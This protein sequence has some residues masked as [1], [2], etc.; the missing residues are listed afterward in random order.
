MIVLAL[1]NLAFT[2]ELADQVTWSDQVLELAV[3]EAGVATGDGLPDGDVCARGP[4]LRGLLTIPPPPNDY[5]WCKGRARR[6]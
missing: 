5:G 4:N 3:A 1:T 6:R 2:T